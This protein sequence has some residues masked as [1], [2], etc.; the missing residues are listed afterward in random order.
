MRSSRVSVWAVG[1]LL[2]VSG[3]A[4]VRQGGPVS[5]PDGMAAVGPAPTGVRGWWSRRFGGGDGSAVQSDLGSIPP[6]RAFPASGGGWGSV[7][8]FSRPPWVTRQ[9]QRAPIFSLNGSGVPAQPKMTP[10]EINEAIARMTGGRRDDDQVLPVRNVDETRL[11]SAEDDG[12]GPATLSRPVRLPDALADA[13]FA[14]ET[15]ADEPR[16]TIPP[17]GATLLGV[18]DAE[19]PAAAARDEARDRLAMAS[20]ARE[21]ASHEAQDGSLVRSSQV[22][23]P[24]PIRPEP[25]VAP[26]EADPVPPPPLDTPRP[27]EAPRPVEAPTLEEP[28]EAPKPAEAPK[29]VEEPKPAEPTPPPAPAPEPPAP[30]PK[31]AE[32]IAPEAA[33]PAPA[34]VEAPKPEPGDLDVAPPPPTSAPQPQVQAQSQP[35][36]PT[37]QTP[38]Y[39]AP[40]A[41]A[42]PEPAPRAHRWSF[43]NWKSGGHGHGHA[44][45]SPQSPAAL[46]PVMFPTSYESVWAKPLVPSPQATP[47]VAPSPQAETAAEKP[48]WL[49][50]RLKTRAHQFKAWKHEHICKHIQNFKAALKGEGCRACKEAVTASPQAVPSPQAAPTPQAKPS[51]QELPVIGGSRFGLY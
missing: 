35:P 24:P 39:S 14:D 43:W 45:A 30:A 44:E 13:P 51:P 12:E 47:Q 36:A 31:P 9:P 3:C 26:P 41:T 34:A 21:T 20:P 22:P 29:P 28:V 8:Q 38:T 7:Y 32:A 23:P 42:F 49:V 50:D 15:I 2:G 27:E 16:P 10:A 46:P 37:T 25:G 48:C 40:V 5:A 4:G 6:A 17:G 18:R 11:A 1:L 19:E 33:K